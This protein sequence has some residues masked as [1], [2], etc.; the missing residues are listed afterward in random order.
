M[1]EGTEDDRKIE[2]ES[3]REGIKNKKQARKREIP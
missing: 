2:T 3:E 1:T